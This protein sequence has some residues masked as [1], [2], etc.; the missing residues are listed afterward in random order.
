M[1]PEEID[2]TT[3]IVKSG[4]RGD[5]VDRLFFNC[6]RRKRIL[7]SSTV[8]SCF[9]FY[10]RH[11]ETAAVPFPVQRRRT[12]EDYFANRILRSR[13]IPDQPCEVGRAPARTRFSF[14]ACESLW[15][16]VAFSSFLMQN[17]KPTLSPYGR[18]FSGNFGRINRCALFVRRV[19]CPCTGT[20]GLLNPRFFCSF[21]PPPRVG[22][23]K[24]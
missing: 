21:S 14:R 11:P 9:V 6:S 13:A 24:L 10:F 5:R 7:N 2:S 17:P 4:R 16:Q 12:E 20:T 1:G 15:R 18:L 19:R 22:A 8:S 23:L 3:F